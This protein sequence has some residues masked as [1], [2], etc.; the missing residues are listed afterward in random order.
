MISCT[1]PRGMHARTCIL[2]RRIAPLSLFALSAPFGLTAL[3]VKE[4]RAWPRRTPLS[5]LPQSMYGN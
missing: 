1:A 2:H 3:L 5:V 4:L